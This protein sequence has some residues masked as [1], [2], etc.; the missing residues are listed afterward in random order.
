M[1][2]WM[3]MI[4]DCARYEPDRQTWLWIL[5]FINVPGAVIYFIARHLP[6]SAAL[7]A[8]ILVKMH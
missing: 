1:A 3:L 8:T 2:F 6:R 5:L 4:F 7:P